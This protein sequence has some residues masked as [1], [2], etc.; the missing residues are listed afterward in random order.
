MIST[1]KKT[2][3]RVRNLSVGVA[4]KNGIKPILRDVSF[5]LAEQK[6]LGIIGETGSGKS[7]LSRAV[8]AWLTQPLVATA[9]TVEFQGHDRQGGRHEQHCCFEFCF[10]FAHQT[11][12]LCGNCYV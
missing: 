4:G 12:D 7:V 1:P 2:L 8:A 9:G 11:Q 5:D 6:I 10:Q 3:L